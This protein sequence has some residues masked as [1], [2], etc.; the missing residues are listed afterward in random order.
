MGVSMGLP[1]K[2]WIMHWFRHVAV[3]LCVFA[4]PL[5]AACASP[6]GA[7][8]PAA[9][10]RTDPDAVA[11]AILDGY[12]AQDGAV[13]AA[14]FNETNQRQFAAG[15][16]PSEGFEELFDGARAQA[17]ISWDGEHLPARFGP[18]TRGG[19]QAII[20]FALETGAAPASIAGASGG[21]YLVI[22]L[23]LDDAADTS[24]GFE[25]I[26][27]YPASRYEALSVCPKGTRRRERCSGLR[28]D[29]ADPAA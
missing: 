11:V 5:L 8:D 22:V 9:L 24:W 17:A 12:R 7:L 28:L 27:R 21:S 25:D 29:I 19:R 13:I 26:N 10:D 18:G 23:T 16:G 15:R 2:G 6:P 14:Y 20:P 4:L 1:H 3:M